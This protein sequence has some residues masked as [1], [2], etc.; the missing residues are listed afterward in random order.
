[1]ERSA[2]LQRH[3]SALDLGSDEGDEILDVA[4]PEGERFEPLAELF[5]LEE[6]VV[7]A[8]AVW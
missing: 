8:R 2:Y 6:G 7:C 4:D 5:R 1:M 3:A